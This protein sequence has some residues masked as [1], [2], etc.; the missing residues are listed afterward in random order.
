VNAVRS[1]STTYDAGYAPPT[2]DARL[3]AVR[4]L[5]HLLDSAFRIPGTQVRVGLDPLLGLLPGIGDALGGVASLYAIWVAWQLGAPASVLGRMVLNVAIDSAVGAVPILGD[6]FDAGFR[7]NLRNVRL[8]EGWLE[9]PR[10]ARRAS[11]LAVAAALVAAALAVGACA[12]LVW[13]AFGV[14]S[15]RLRA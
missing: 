5:A 11:V 12:A 3:A 8:L 1:S 4:A 13:W 6:A 9:R 14:V 2:R 7:S 15:G 10:Q